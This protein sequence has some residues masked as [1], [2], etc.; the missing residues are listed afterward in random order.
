MVLG[1]PAGGLWSQFFSWH[2][3][4]LGTAPVLSLFL[5]FGWMVFPLD[6]SPG[7]RSYGLHPL[8]FLPF[9]FFLLGAVLALSLGNKIGWSSPVVIASGGTAL[10]A[11]VALVLQRRYG[12]RPYPS[13]QLL[14]CRGFPASLGVLFVFQAT[15][16]GIVFLIPFYLELLCGLS[17][18]SSSMLLLVYPAS[19]ALSSLWGGRMADRLD[20]RPLIVTAA[21]LGAITCGLFSLLLGLG[22]VP[23]AALFLLLFGIA[24]GLF[25]PPNNRFAMTCVTAD[26]QREAGALLPV[27]LN[28]GSVVGVAFYDELFTRRIPDA[29][30][31]ILLPSIHSN[32][33]MALLNHGFIDAFLA[34]A[35]ALLMAAG[36]AFA[37]YRKSSSSP[38]SATG[39]RSAS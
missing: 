19:L 11:F 2:W 9:S 31:G 36:M 35:T 6:A 25:F 22:A 16:G 15:V 32:N 37:W 12:T 33:V 38:A 20:S 29:A 23:I 30:F 39:H 3:I 34:A 8:Q 21:L 5:A 26:L 27:A 18:L 1:L 10:L 24:T 13:E 28:M 7:E 4:F 17:T 14:Q